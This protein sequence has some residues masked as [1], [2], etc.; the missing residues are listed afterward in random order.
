MRVWRV[1]I[2]RPAIHDSI[3]IAERYVLMVEYSPKP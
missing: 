3:V 2:G 1:M